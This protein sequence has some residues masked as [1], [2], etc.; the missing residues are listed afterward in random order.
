MSRDEDGAMGT[1]WPYDVGGSAVERNKCGNKCGGIS[2]SCKEPVR[3][4]VTSNSIMG[5]ISLLNVKGHIPG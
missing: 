2:G 1:V 3:W 5:S 4:M